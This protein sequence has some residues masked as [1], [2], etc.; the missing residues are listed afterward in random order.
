MTQPI[1]DAL[2]LDDLERAYD[3]LAHAIDQAGAA[4]TERLLVKLAL[5]QVQALGDLQRFRAHLEVALQDL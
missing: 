5:L 4:H 3:D 1:P 2:S